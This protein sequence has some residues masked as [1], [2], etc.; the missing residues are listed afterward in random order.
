[1]RNKPK[2]LYA[3][4]LMKNKGRCHA[5]QMQAVSKVAISK[6]NCL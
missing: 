6:G 1:M 4:P 5:A 2:L 3:I